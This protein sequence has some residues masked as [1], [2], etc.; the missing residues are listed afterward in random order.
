MNMFAMQIA[1]VKDKTMFFIKGDREQSAP[2]VNIYFY[3]PT[4]RESNECGSSK[5]NK[6]VQQYN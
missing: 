6:N 4:S 1:W 2:T 3:C 5:L